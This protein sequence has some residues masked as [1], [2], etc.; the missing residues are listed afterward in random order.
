MTK[1]P[2][3]DFHLSTCG[4]RLSFLILILIMHLG[5]RGLAC[6]IYCCVNSIRLNLSPHA[7]PKGKQG[8][9]NFHLSLIDYSSR[10]DEEKPFPL[11]SFIGPIKNASCPTR[12]KSFSSSLLAYRFTLRPDHVHLY[13]QPQIKK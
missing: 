9:G 10:R 7:I 2:R 3:S 11:L 6:L 4:T 13:Q 12:E 5:K 1:Y 8:L